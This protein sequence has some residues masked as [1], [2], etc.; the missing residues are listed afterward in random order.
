LPL[1][2]PSSKSVFPLVY[3]PSFLPATSSN[4]LLKKM[5]TLILKFTPLPSGSHSISL[6]VAFFHVS[7]LVRM[8]LQW[9][10]ADGKRS[11]F[12]TIFL[13]VKPKRLFLAFPSKFRLLPFHR[14]RIA[15]Y[16]Y[17]FEEVCTSNVLLSC[18]SST[19]RAQ[20]L[21]TISSGAF[22]ESLR[23]KRDTLSS[24]G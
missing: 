1:S 16:P 19:P 15:C 9:F 18:F 14:V 3:F 4:P 8:G 5:L 22:L 2:T 6:P 17:V 12:L 11:L 10:L 7:K 24:A 20:F 13:L 23:E 21:I